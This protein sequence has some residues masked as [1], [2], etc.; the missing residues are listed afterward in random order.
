[1]KEKVLV[2]MSGGVDSSVAA[3]MLKNQ[4]YEVIGATIKTWRDAYYDSSF[5]D[6]SD[7]CHVCETLGIPHVI[8]DAQEIFRQCVVEPFAQEYIHGRT[9]NP[10]V[11][12]N[13]AVKWGALLKEADRQDAQYIATGHYAQ[14]LRLSNGRYSISLSEGKAKDQSYVLGR[15][16]Q[17]QLSRTLMPLG[18]ATKDWVRRKAAEIGLHVSEKKDSQEICF[19]PDNDHADFLSRN[20]GDL[21]PAPGSFIDQEG[22]VLGTHRGIVHYTIGQRKHL[23]L[24]M[25]HPV[26][27]TEIR[28][29]TN[30][31]VIG[32]NEALFKKTIYAEQL[33]YVGLAPEED[34]HEFRAKAKIRYAHPETDCTVYLT[35]PDKITVLFDAPVRAATP[36]QAIVIYK[37]DYILLSGMITG[38]GA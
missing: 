33:N 21:L 4:G 19:I 11:L 3:W 14:I 9:P 37:D 29:E 20:F 26:Y 30:E 1:M 15:L 24:A 25:G 6:M 2:G 32:E 8:I 22:Q 17:E 10:C 36:G 18:S 34:H 23:N 5:S 16:S 27:V 7:A 12:C 35:A 28:P 31:V 38:T 13:H